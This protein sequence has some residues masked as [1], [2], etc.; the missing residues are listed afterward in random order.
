MVC[1]WFTKRLCR[2]SISSPY[3]LVHFQLFDPI[4]W[5]KMKRARLVPLYCCLVGSL[6]EVCW[7]IERFLLINETILR[8]MFSESLPK[9]RSY[10]ACLFLFFEL[11]PLQQIGDFV[12]LP[13]TQIGRFLEEHSCLLLQNAEIS[14]ILGRSLPWYVLV[15]SFHL[16]NSLDDF[17]LDIYLST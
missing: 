11:L 16:V 1:V 8:T 7:V 12:L 14:I 4:I 6:V 10:S 2:L 15:V 3:S 13:N 9:N 5:D 17:M